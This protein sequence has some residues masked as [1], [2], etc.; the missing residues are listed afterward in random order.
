VERGHQCPG[1][2]ELHAE[3]GE[4]RGQQIVRKRCTDL[5]EIAV[6]DLA[7]LDAGR[8]VE[9]EALVEQVEVARPERG[10][11]EDDECQR[12]GKCAVKRLQGS[13]PASLSREGALRINLL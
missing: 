13:T 7:A 12:G 8:F 2:E 9:E 1:D 3:Y 10:V 6:D 4:R 5:E 11:G